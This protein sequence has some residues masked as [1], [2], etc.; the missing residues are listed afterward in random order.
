MTAFKSAANPMM[1]SAFAETIFNQKYRHE[2]AETWGELAD[3]LVNDVCS[4]LVPDEVM[5]AIKEAIR[6]MKFIPGGRYLYYAGRPH[7]FY[8]N[9]YLLKAE[10]D[11][12][13]DWA[14]LS[15]KS[16][17]CLMTGGGIGADYSIY[18]EAGAVIKRTG[19][20]ASGPI[21]KMMMINEIGR[22]VMQGGSRR[23]AIYASLKWDHPDAKDFLHTKDWFRKIPGTDL[24]FADVKKLDF[25]FPC[26]LDMTNISLNYDTKWLRD[27]MTDTFVNNVRQ[28]LK[29]GEPGFS[30]NFFHKE[31][32]TLRNACT[33]VVSE[34]DSDVCNL[35]SIN[36]GRIE[37]LRE[38]EIITELAV[39]FL[40]CGG[41]T[42]HLP[43]KKIERV[44]AKNNRIGLGI[45]GLHEWLIQRNYKY[46]MVPELERMLITWS[47]TSESAAN[48]WS[49]ALGVAR[50]K[51]VRAIAPTGTIGLIADTTTG[52]EPLFAVAYKRRFLKGTNWNYQYVVD[53]T[54]QHLIDRYGT[55][56]DTI[57]TA[58][59]LSQDVERRIATQASVQDH[60][61]MSISSTI[62]M[63]AWGTEGNNEGRVMEFAALIAR[64]APRL[65]G[66]T[67]YP[68]GARGGQPL[69]PIEYNDA[70]HMQGHTFE[71][72][73]H[74][75]CDISGKGG[76]CGA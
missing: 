43:Y 25:D 5:G 28:A 73:A 38:L 17:S 13:E 3:T 34:D 47:G 74:D 76:V 39:I 65:R 56:P 70:K 54:A 14:N 36:L 50:P 48:W 24:T 8:N 44:R 63:P 11:S 61:D 19:G 30:F 32:E 29:S 33:E 31:N 40:L 6:E 7:R 12:R 62:N 59:S 45:M 52:I 75:I 26:P 66:L 1:R 23:S 9:C 18:R 58:L 51:G 20:L 10:E 42:A 4:G 68:D 53:A 69:T 35:G 27:P 49:A 41:K 64:Y 21:P 55:D 46:G 72:R 67:V 22:R 71:E 16:E 15:W 2:G 60:V 37:N 57:E